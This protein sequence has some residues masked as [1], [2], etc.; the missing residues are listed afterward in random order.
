[1]LLAT[2][3][4]WN[5]CHWGWMRSWSKAPAEQLEQGSTLPPAPAES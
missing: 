2:F 1:M 4:H 5:C 3:Q